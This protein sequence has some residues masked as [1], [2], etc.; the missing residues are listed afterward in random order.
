MKR[1]TFDTETWIG[2][3]EALLKLGLNVS[4]EDTIHVTVH[5]G[6]IDS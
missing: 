3:G 6:P 5:Q 1:K 4:K 2:Q